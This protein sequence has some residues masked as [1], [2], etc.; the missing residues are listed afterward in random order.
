MIDNLLCLEIMCDD[1]VDVINEAEKL[2]D[3]RSSN[4]SEDDDA[5]P[6]IHTDPS[7]S[8]RSTDASIKD[9]KIEA[10]RSACAARNVPALADLSTT[11]GGFVADE[12]RKDACMVS[13]LAG[14]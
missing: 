10:I 6:R 14:D 2:P 3:R 9:A 8:Q 5:V 11:P 12:L 1:D 7:Q 13:L 4:I